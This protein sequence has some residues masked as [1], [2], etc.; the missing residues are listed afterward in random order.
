MIRATTSLSRNAYWSATNSSHSR[1]PAIA[2][3]LAASAAS[4]VRFRRLKRL[5]CRGAVTSGT[6]ASLPVHALQHLDQPI[7]EFPQLT[8]G[9][10]LQE[11]SGR[12]LDDLR[13]KSVH[14]LRRRLGQRRLQA[15]Q[16]FLPDEDAGLL[17]RC[18]HQDVLRP[19][20]IGESRNHARVLM[21]ARE[22]Q[23]FVAQLHGPQRHGHQLSKARRGDGEL[24][25]HDAASHAQCAARSACG[26]AEPASA[27]VHSR[28]RLPVRRG[29]GP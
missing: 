20:A 23:D 1:E 9:L 2:R 28:S 12:L 15:A 10:A 27:A 21:A 25:P 14:G 5:A 18:G 29:A 6:P 3:D 19:P 7:A 11:G 17:P 4:L 22:A 8:P 24:P 16:I 26:R 13:V